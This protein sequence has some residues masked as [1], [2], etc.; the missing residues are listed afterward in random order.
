MD[1]GCELTE[2]KLKK[3]KRNRR[4]RFGVHANGMV[5]VIAETLLLCST[6]KAY[7]TQPTAASSFYCTRPSPMQTMAKKESMQG[8]PTHVAGSELIQ[9]LGPNVRAA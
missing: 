3:V 1:P 6:C 8:S 5:A 9:L 7:S 4:S 2:T